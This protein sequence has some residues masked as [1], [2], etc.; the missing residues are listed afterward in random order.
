VRV[1]L[2]NQAVSLALV[3]G[4]GVATASAIAH[5]PTVTEFQTG[6]TPTS[7]PWGITEGPGDKLWFTENGASA[8]GSL[9]ADTNVFEELTGLSIVGNA[10]G[11]VEGPDGNLWVAQTAAGGKIAQIT[12][13]GTVTE[14][15]AHEDPAQSTYPVDI[16]SG[17]D[18]NLW[19]VS[20][21]PEFVGRITPAGVVTTFTVG[22]TP[23]SDL[24]SITV[25]P[26]ENLWFTEAADP[27]RIGRITAAGVITEFSAGLS[28]NMAPTDITA[29]PDGKL[30]FT[31]SADPGGIGR[32][33]TSGEITEF[34]DGLTPNSQPRSIA[35]GNDD[36]VWFTESASPGAIGR[37]TADG[38]I[39][40]HT[41]GLTPDSSPW[42]ITEGPDGNM[43]F[44]GNADPGLVG[45]ITVPPAVKTHP[46]Q[47]VDGESASLRAKIG[48]NAQDTSYH[49]EYGP[50]AEIGSE[51][52]E[53][54]AGNGWK[55]VEF[56]T[57][58]SDLAAETTY[59]YRAVATNSAGTTIGDIRSFKT[60]SA[61]TG[62]NPSPTPEKATDK[63]P[64]FAETVVARAKAGT[65][66]YR[67]PGGRW[68]RL[69][70]TGAE[71]PL[72]AT[73][74]ARQGSIA[75]TTVARGGETQT[76]SFG[77]G[78]FSV[79]QPRTAHGRVD[80]YLRGG[81]FARRCRR[82]ARAGS[83][84]NSSSVR[85][86]RRLWGRDSGGRFR[87]HGRHS[88][89]TVRGTRW[90][91][92]DRC[93]GTFTRVTNGAVVVRDL[94]RRRSVVVRAG[95]SYFAPRPHRPRRRR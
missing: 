74:D 2:F 1:R 15:E 39:T 79:R 59:F 34:S 89:A 36:A 28:P 52:A 42:G 93:S 44:T 68:R 13:G 67:P 10:R 49:F 76:G 12:P 22:L 17:P 8:L 5:E 62:P 71:V 45:R 82:P 72:G 53:A 16:T 26:D 37:V 51:T 9:T 6:L 19:Y 21:S 54:D 85:R 20:Q 73:V 70:I 81:N 58:L 75:L 40:E 41:L 83:I 64:D 90:L 47:F 31:E 30:W 91:T 38:V 4:L 50:T 84:A 29:G 7:G 69:P 18:G 27:G 80:L 63:L 11:I 3:L 56:D 35:E 23:N 14:F 92:E 32:I 86:V 25:G 95:H 78:I 60:K 55:S 66:R 88:H 33:S 87:T 77:G 94:T 43:W 65:I 61:S 57:Q 24:S 46:P 48:A